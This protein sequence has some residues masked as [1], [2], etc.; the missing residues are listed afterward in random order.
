MSLSVALNLLRTSWPWVLR[1][2][3][4]VVTVT[5]QYRWCSRLPGPHHRFDP[6]QAKLKQL[7]GPF[8]DFDHLTLTSKYVSRPSEATYSQATFVNNQVLYIVQPVRLIEEWGRCRW[9]TM[10]VS[11]EPI[12][13]CSCSRGSAWGCRPG[14]LGRILIVTLASMAQVK[15]HSTNVGEAPRSA[16]QVT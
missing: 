1:Y 9:W 15:I 12:S 7:D 13:E 4:T 11:A 8:D 6:N 14:C 10:R 5:K 3:R 16:A 2:R